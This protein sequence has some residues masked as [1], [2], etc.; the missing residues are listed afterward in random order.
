MKAVKTFAFCAGLLLA[1]T[2][3]VAA[4]RPGGGFS[5]HGG[6]SGGHSF[7]HGG[8]HGSY[9]GSYHGGG[10]GGG[11]SGHPGWYG[12]HWHGGWY[13]GWGGVY[14][15]PW[16]GVGAYSYPY[17]YYSYPD[18][19]VAPAAPVYVE[20]NAAAVSPSGSWYYCQDPAGYYPYVKSCNGAW[21]QVPAQP[22]AQ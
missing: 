16:W 13:G 18:V 5:G 2:A 14:I 12:N 19:V 8:Y 11:W 4:A 3:D 21:Q 9:S 10:W 22:P 6:F 20:P 1:A 17:P 7:G 15:D